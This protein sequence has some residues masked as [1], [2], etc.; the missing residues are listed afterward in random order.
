[1]YLCGAGGTWH[2]EGCQGLFRKR[3]RSQLRV[4][5]CAQLPLD[6]RLLEEHAVVSNFAT[7]ITT[8]GATNAAATIAGICTISAATFHGILLHPTRIDLL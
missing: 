6:H 1:M 7:L 8:V 2:V 4:P 3:P 5:V